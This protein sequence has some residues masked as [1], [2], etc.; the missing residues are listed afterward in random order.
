METLF[1]KHNILKL[2]LD[3]IENLRR[4]MFLKIPS[5]SPCHQILGPDGFTSKYYQLHKKEIIP[6][7]H[8]LFQKNR[9]G[10]TF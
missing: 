5:P 10:D 8:K 4:P 7:L 3:E 6:I 9:E 1:E 2:T